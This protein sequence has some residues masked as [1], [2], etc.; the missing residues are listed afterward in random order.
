M[1]PDGRHVYWPADS[2]S[3]LMAMGMGA[4]T[5]LGPL[6]SRNSNPTRRRYHHCHYGEIDETNQSKR[7]S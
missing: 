2:G 6:G 5:I 7:S 3:N 4:G 1:R